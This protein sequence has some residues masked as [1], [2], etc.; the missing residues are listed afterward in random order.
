[1]ADGQETLP[2][3]PPTP[4]KQSRY[5]GPSLGGLWTEFTRPMPTA[6]PEGQIPPY[7]WLDEN[8]VQ[9]GQIKYNA[10]EIAKRGGAGVQ[11]VLQ[12]RPQGPPA[13]SGQIAGRGAPAAAAA[14]TPQQ[15]ISPLAPP[16]AR[17]VA[18][19]IPRGGRVIRPAQTFQQE[20]G[21]RESIQGRQLPPL[22]Q[23]GL[24][25]RKEAAI[26]QNESMRQQ[27][28]A[29]IEQLGAQQ[30]LD[31]Q[32]VELNR[33]YQAEIKGRQQSRQDELA[34]W[35]TKRKATLAEVDE[36]KIED[37]WADKSTG[38]KIL[39]AIAVGMGSFAARQRGG[40]PNTAMQIIDTAIARDLQVQ[41]DN[42]NKGRAR[43]EDLDGV[44]ARMR[45]EYDD[46]LQA[47]NMANL[48]AHQGVLGQVKALQTQ[49]QR[50]DVKAG[51]AGIEGDL[52]DKIG[53]L[54]MDAG[55]I[56][57]VSTDRN[58]ATVTTPAVVGG[59]EEIEAQIAK[60]WTEYGKDKNFKPSQYVKAY[61]GYADTEKEAITMRNKA[62]ARTVM[63]K[64][65][66]KLITFREKY[67][68]EAMPSEAYSE[69][70]TVWNEA[71]F[72]K[73]DIDELGI[74]SEGDIEL[75][76]KSLP[77]PGQKW[78]YAASQYNTYLKTIQMEEKTDAYM[79]V[80]PAFNIPE[81]RQGTWKWGP[82]GGGG[83]TQ[84]SVQA[85]SGTGGTLD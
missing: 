1:M 47:A 53:R 76:K 39:A 11:R 7:K 46:D 60:G 70:M 80:T 48:A 38:T 81:A 26:I 67:G 16:A 64:L 68:T 21:R 57:Q 32:Q 2:V 29:R 85:E 30:D 54:N 10:D 19:V 44:M 33:Q 83:A 36:M 59:G 9:I 8:T 45:L 37:Y 42:I 84:Q 27:G 22:T 50:D 17:Q 52:L 5:E 43:L 63:K 35:Q 6:G 51:L 24:R 25:Q 73:K 78:T 4:P 74:L 65:L 34:Q 12:T 77:E 71:F 79:R 49:A 13:L 41:R 40:G 61:N 62:V 72:K 14:P 69:I 82:K 20:V 58:I 23:E 28:Q 66:N 18:P 56:E 75:I 31:L 15:P 3:T 55:G